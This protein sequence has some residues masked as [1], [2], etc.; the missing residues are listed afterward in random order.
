MGRKLS[1]T[2]RKVQDFNSKLLVVPFRN[3]KLDYYPGNFI[4]SRTFKYKE[5][6]ISKGAELEKG[7]Y[8]YFQ[9]AVDVAFFQGIA[10]LK[11]DETKIEQSLEDGISVI[12]RDI[13]KLQTS[14]KFD[15]MVFPLCE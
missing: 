6:I 5:K 14:E 2:L 12:L 1:I 8:I 15:S 3:I 10:F 9:K 7:G 13:G 4:L 11:V